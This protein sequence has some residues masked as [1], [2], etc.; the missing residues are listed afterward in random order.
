MSRYRPPAD[1][2]S[3]YITQE[4]FEHLQAEEKTLWLKRRKVVT[5]LSAA[6]AEGD[7]S[8]NAEYI[9]RKKELRELDYRIRYLQKRLPDLTVVSE[10][11]HLKDQV[12]FSALITLE[13]EDGNE[14]TYR[15]VGPDEIDHQAHYISMDSP[16]AKALFKKQ[17]GD[18]VTVNTPASHQTF[19]IISISYE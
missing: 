3:P 10:K 18:E 4:G 17:L 1:K 13:D 16:V 12:F 7:R 15:I 19:I 8:E 5:A 9:Y 14:I 6:A 11:P 2:K